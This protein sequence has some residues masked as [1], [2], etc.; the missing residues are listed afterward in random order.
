MGEKVEVFHKLL[1]AHSTQKKRPAG[2][3]KRAAAGGNPSEKS[4]KKTE[5]SGLVSLEKEEERVGGRVAKMERR[6]L[7]LESALAKAT[8]R[9]GDTPD[10]RK[11]ERGNRV[12]GRRASSAQVVITASMSKPSEQGNTECISGCDRSNVVET[13]TPDTVN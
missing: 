7:E 3:G 8:G 4:G 9:H 13:V 11:K 6:I 2:T 1:K 12:E 10:E 5:G